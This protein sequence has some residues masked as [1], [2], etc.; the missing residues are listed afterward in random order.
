MYARLPKGLLV[1]IGDV[2]LDN[3]G[4]KNYT[5][6]RLEIA[7]KNEWDFNDNDVDLLMSIASAI[8]ANH[9]KM[10]NLV[11]RLFGYDSIVA[12]QTWGDQNIYIAIVESAYEIVNIQ[13]L[14]DL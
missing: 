10:A 6:N 13:P 4:E 11:N 14:T 12:P 5:P 2:Y 3:W 8:G 7:I 1:E 9:E